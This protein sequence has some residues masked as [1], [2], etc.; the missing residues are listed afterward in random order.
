MSN[1]SCSI[2]EIYSDSFT[3]NIYTVTHFRMI[4]LIDVNIQYSY[5]IEK[6]TLGFYSSSGTNNGK[7]K[8]LWYPIVGIK[9]QT[10]PF[11]EFTDYINSVLTRTTSHGSAHKGWLAKSL[12]FYNDA[13]GSSALDGF[14]TG[15]YYEPLLKIGKTLRHAYAVGQFRNLTTLNAAYLNT[16][17]LSS[18]VY[19]GNTH[20]QVENYE[21]YIYDILHA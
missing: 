8:G 19:P 12:F 15:K 10:G 2:L 3:A 1:N 21:K 11:T 7:I 16:A 13:P 17:L 9:L 6:V 20:S 18:E 4:G 14:S 5:G